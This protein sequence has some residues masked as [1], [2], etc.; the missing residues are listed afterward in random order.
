M[1]WIK[2]HYDGV[3]LAVAALVALA[4]A[5]VATLG[6]FSF[7]EIFAE[8]NSAKPR[9]NNVAEAEVSAWLQAAESITAHPK[10]EG[11]DGSLFTSRVYILKGGELVDPI[12]GDRPLHPPIPN[13]WLLKYDLDYTQG[14][15]LETDVDGDGFT[16]LEEWRA[17]TD[18]TDEESMPPLWTKL[19]LQNYERI[20]FKVKFSGTPDGG[21]TFTINF[22]DDRTQP[23]QF[24]NIGQSVSIAG[25]PYTLTKFERKMTVVNDIERD[26]SELTIENK[27]TGEVIVLVNDQIVDSPTTFG[28]FINLLDG[29]LI[30][31]IK[32]GETFSL[33]QDPET[34]YRLEE[35]SEV[36]AV[37]IKD[38]TGDRLEIP[39]L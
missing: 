20:P 33:A 31:N 34:T 14:D 28:T 38:S 23:T 13:E 3:I 5:G 21:E 32:R 2:K 18:P 27:A 36:Q 22:I 9:D 8:R 4:C 10:W 19:R 39:A 16:V 24:L 37:V 1:D 35:I 15:I 7:E 6:V 25:V 29:N 11:H 30:E 17:G 12:E 26:V